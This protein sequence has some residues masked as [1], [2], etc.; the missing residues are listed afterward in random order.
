M[1]STAAQF[2]SNMGY[3]YFDYTR[4]PVHEW[5]KTH[6][7]CGW[8]FGKD[9]TWVGARFFF[10]NE[11]DRDVF[12]MIFNDGIY[13]S[14]CRYIVEVPD[15]HPVFPF[16]GDQAFFD[17]GYE[18]GILEEQYDHLNFLGWVGL[19]TEKQVAKAALAGYPT[20]ALEPYKKR[21]AEFHAAI[22]EL[23]L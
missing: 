3:P 9:Y 17:I 19:F 23:G 22:V 4:E 12:R 8:V 13:V 10:N 18:L 2:L 15:R 14:D 1:G 20:I 6:E 11:I 16:D 21:I 7:L 5:T